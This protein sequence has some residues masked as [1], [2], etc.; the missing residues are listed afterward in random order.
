MTVEPTAPA[1]SVN[2]DA[3]AQIGR[4]GVPAAS[5]AP[6]PAAPATERRSRATLLLASIAV[7]LIALEITIIA[8]ALPDIELAFPSSSR[9]T[10][11]WI[12]TA[13]NVGV[14]ALMLIAGWLAERFGRKRVFLIG[15][16]VFAAG[17]VVS[18]MAP[19]VA[20]LIIG[21]LIQAVGGAAL[22]PASLALILHD[23]PAD[24]RD[25]AIGVW[26]AMAGLAAAVGPTLGALLVDLAGWRWVFL[27]NVPI[28]LAALAAGPRLL[29]E[30]RDPNAPR[31]VDLWA[32]PLGAAGVA[33]A[34]FAI[35]A[36]GVRGVA[37]PLV[38]GCAGASIALLAVFAHRTRNH[39]SP[40][41][42]PQIA[43]LRSYRVGALA[44]LLFGAA[45]AGWLVLLPTY[46]VSIR[47]FSVIEAGFGIAPAPL[48]MMVVAGPAGAL[49]ARFGHRRVIAAGSALGA[50]ATALMLVTVTETSSYVTGFLPGVVLLGVSV[51]VG[52]PML[53][54]ASMR[55]VP[56]HR[57]AVAAAGN[58]TVRQ[59]AIALGI[60]I[61]VALVGTEGS[62][63]DELADFH[64]SWAVC[65]V[66]FLLT[67]IVIG[68]AYPDAPEAP[69]RRDSNGTSDADAAVEPAA[70]GGRS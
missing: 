49:C 35:T 45:F 60:S 26:G 69:D 4:A 12:F 38:L 10:L 5:A 66:L 52:F 7:F 43:R 15:M 37:D 25:A 31:E 41:F 53:T 58:T 21:R 67:A 19:T 2:A 48:A 30:S 63:S 24:R 47:G 39:P 50:L 27:I 14:A 18:G 1:A 42:A 62:R 23:T 56:E 32:P 65:G 55:D 20:V 9:A 40:L 3:A 13:Y 17:S 59:V 68:V 11:S 28:A 51:G 44:T 36:A 34:V 54:A 57:Y 22:L 6:E 16:A 64:L 70:D 46:L 29:A 8:V 33:A 61:A